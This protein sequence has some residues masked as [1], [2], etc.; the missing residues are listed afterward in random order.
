M[1]P[2]TCDPECSEC[3]VCLT[4]LGKCY[5]QAAGERCSVGECDGLG[6]CKVSTPKD[7]CFHNA[8]SRSCAPTLHLQGTLHAVTSAASRPWSGHELFSL[9]AKTCPACSECQTCNG[10]T[11]ACDNKPP[12]TLCF[13]G[14]CDKLGN[15]KPRTCPTCN[16]C[17]A[18]NTVTGICD[19]KPIGEPCSLGQCDGVGACEVSTC[20]GLARTGCCRSWRVPSYSMSWENIFKSCLCCH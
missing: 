13:A 4:M 14:Q 2:L 11:G 16:E 19:P 6:T 7:E 18:C 8:L 12:G 15:C 17:Q 10:I 5:N 3:Q 1:Q 20:W 9:Q